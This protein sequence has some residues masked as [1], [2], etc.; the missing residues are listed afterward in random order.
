MTRSPNTPIPEPG[1]EE[2]ELMFMACSYSR[3]ATAPVRRTFV[4]RQLTP[5]RGTAILLVLRDTGLRASERCALKVEELDPKTGKVHIK[6]GVQ[7][8]A[9]GGKGRTIIS[10]RRH[11][12]SFGVVSPGARMGSRPTLPCMSHELAAR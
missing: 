2:V 10:A 5:N 8:G 4:I 7:G 9:K 6:Q 1:R 3:E 11:G 12:G